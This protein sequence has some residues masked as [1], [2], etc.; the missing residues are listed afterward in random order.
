MTIVRPI[1]T[2]AEMQLSATGRSCKF[3][4]ASVEI[5]YD[6]LKYAHEHPYVASNDWE[7][8]ERAPPARGE[9]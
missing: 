1:L 7:Q 9:Y 2:Y 4:R 5:F 3:R 6:R 8:P